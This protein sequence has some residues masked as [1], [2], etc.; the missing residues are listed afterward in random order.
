[1]GLLYWGLLSKVLEMGVCFH[2]GPVLGYLGGVLFQS[3]LEKGKILFG[4]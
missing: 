1:M 3:L 4:T 2:K